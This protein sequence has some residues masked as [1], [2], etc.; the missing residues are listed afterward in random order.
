MNTGAMRAGLAAMLGVTLM[1]AGVARAADLPAVRHDGE[2][3]YLTGG[4]GQDESSA[5]S[6][7]QRQWPL[8]LEFAEQ[9]GGRAVYVADVD[10]V[11]RNASGQAALE[12]QADGPFLLAKLP[13][14]R[15]AVEASWN[16]KTLREPVTIKHGAPAHATFVWPAD[17]DDSVI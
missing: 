8:S 4:V 17:M 11:V 14:G 13:P 2:V 5:I 12:A 9:A 1:G 16:G 6:A 7:V 15:Y 3:A 10:V